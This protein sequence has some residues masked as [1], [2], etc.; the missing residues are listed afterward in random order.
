M[1]T[2]NLSSAFYAPGTPPADAAEMRRFLSE[3]LAK[4]QSA[5]LALAAGH[6]DVSTSAPSKPRSGDVRYA[7][8]T[9]W[10]PGSGQGVYAYYGAAWHF[11]G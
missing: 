5:F 3:E 4:I 6:L 2:P 10:N 11:L 1:R 9:A 7:D 8:G